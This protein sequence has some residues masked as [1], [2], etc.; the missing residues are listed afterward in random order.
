MSDAD[1]PD[2][3][4]TPDL[5]R[6]RI[7][8]IRQWHEEAL[9][10]AREEAGNDGQTFDYL[11][12]TLHVPPRVQPITGMSYLLGEAVMAEVSPGDRVLDIGTG[13]GVNGILAARAGAEVLAL[14]VNP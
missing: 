5:P 3:G 7:E 2:T 4:Y 8:R 13:C 1:R 10:A 9:R 14:D 11:G 12:L 6:K